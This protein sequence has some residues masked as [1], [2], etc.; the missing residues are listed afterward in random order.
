MK[1][2]VLVPAFLLPV[3]TLAQGFAPSALRA[4]DGSDLTFFLKRYDGP[5]AVFRRATNG[6]RHT[7]PR[8]LQVEEVPVRRAVGL[9]ER[10]QCVDPGYVPCAAY[11]QCCPAGAT[12][13]PGTCCPAGS[14]Q[15]TGQCKNR[16][17]FSHLSLRS[18]SRPPGCKDI[19]GD[20]CPNVGCCPS[21]QV[22]T[23]TPTTWV[24]FS[25]VVPQVCFTALNGEIGCCP[26]GKRC[27]TISGE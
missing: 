14:L 5:V 8:T 11:A 19:K 15:C 16:S 1:F 27:T 18:H 17:H 26:R 13:G 23:C 4:D 10:Q 24:Y 22:R 21:G 9:V 6:K 20:C 25:L 12:C 7:V 2:A 3:V